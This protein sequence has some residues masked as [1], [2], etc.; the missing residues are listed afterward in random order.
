MKD[1]SELVS[2]VDIGF[3]DTKA[4]LL[5]ITSNFIQISIYTHKSYINVQC[6]LI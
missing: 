3:A 2:G 5:Y 1:A 6:G 4:L